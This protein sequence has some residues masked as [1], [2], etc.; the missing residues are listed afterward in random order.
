M[1][2][3]KINTIDEYVKLTATN[4]IGTWYRGLGEANQ[5]GEVLAFE[6]YKVITYA[7]RVMADGGVMLL[8]SPK[9]INL[10]SGGEVSM[11]IIDVVGNT[12]VNSSNMDVPNGEQVA[13]FWNGRNEQGVAVASGLYQA[14]IQWSNNGIKG[15][16]TSIVTIKQIQ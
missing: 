13:L 6:P 9:K 11:T 12:V 15:I 10:I 8:L 16:Q 14:V 4:S 2:E 7:Q 3:I 5:K 1:R